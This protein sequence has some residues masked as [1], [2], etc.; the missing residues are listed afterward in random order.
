MQAGLHKALL[1]KVGLRLGLRRQVLGRQD[2]EEITKNLQD[3]WWQN[4][5]SKY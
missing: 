1:A 4:I 5:S 2:L 3:V